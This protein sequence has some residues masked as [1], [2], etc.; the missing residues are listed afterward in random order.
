MQDANFYVYNVG[1]GVCTLLTGKRK[2]GNDVVP[3]CGI[4]DCGTMSP[5]CY[6]DLN[7]VLRDMVQ[8]IKE[9]KKSDEVKYIDDLVISHQ[10]E[11]HWNRIIDV[12]FALN[13][14][15]NGDY[16]GEK[17]KEIWRLSEDSNK[18]WLNCIRENEYRKYYYTKE[19]KYYCKIQYD[20]KDT[21]VWI[22]I[23]ISPVFDSSMK[24]EYKAELKF[25]DDSEKWY[26]KYEDKYF[27]EEEVDEKEILTKELDEIIDYMGSHLICETEA[28]QFNILLAIADIKVSFDKKNIDEFDAAL[29]SQ[30]LS[31]IKFRVKRAVFGGNFITNG[32]DRMMKIFSLMQEHYFNKFSE[33]EKDGAYLVLNKYTVP[34]GIKDL[35]VEP[36][37]PEYQ[38]VDTSRLYRKYPPNIVRNLTSVVTQLNIDNDHILLLPG[39]VTYHKFS[40]ISEKIESM[41]DNKLSLFLAPHHG[42]DNTNFIPDTE[43]DDPFNSLL[44][45]INKKQTSCNLV[46]SGYNTRR[47]HPG[48]RFTQLSENRLSTNMSVANHKYAYATDIREKPSEGTQQ[49]ETNGLD[50]SETAKRIFTTNCLPLEK[51]LY[52]SKPYF[53]YFNGEILMNRTSKSSSKRSLPPDNSFI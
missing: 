34:G 2:V 49:E 29:V 40:I 48:K 28:D 15:K 13:G 17:G 4:F 47:P 25:D 1:H 6:C 22:Y 53:E 3:Y 50:V 24:R 20:D 12:F 27:R 16:F 5:N 35:K 44:E 7:L 23:T 18:I 26:C 46:I 52:K 36:T 42:S 45:I 31:T 51:E 14:I 32:Y 38:W 9:V 37:H 30:N 8:K 10:D 43:V 41:G 33:W 21:L 39:D 11:D 19:Y